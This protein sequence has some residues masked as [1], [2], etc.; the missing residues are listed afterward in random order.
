MREIR[1]LNNVS[2]TT[3]K[4]RRPQSKMR[5]KKRKQ[6]AILPLAV[7]LLI[8]GAVKFCAGQT[9]LVAQDATKRSE[10]QERLN[11]FDEFSNSMSNAFKKPQSRY[12]N[13]LLM[14]SVI[15]LGAVVV[16]FLVS[17][18]LYQKSRN[19]KEGYYSTE[20]LFKDLCRLHNFDRTDQ[21][22]LRK[23]AKKFQ[24]PNPL[25]L[26]VEP[27]FLEQALAERIVPYTQNQIRK[28]FLELFSTEQFSFTQDEK[29]PSWFAWT[30]IKDNPDSEQLMKKPLTSSESQVQPEQVKVQRWDPA[31]WED[32]DRAVKVFSTAMHPS[33]K[34]KQ[35]SEE[36][37][38]V[39]T[40]SVPSIKSE[41]EEM[42]TEMY[43]APQ[44]ESQP[45]RQAKYRD[46]EPRTDTYINPKGSSSQSPS[47]PDMSAPQQGID[48]SKRFYSPEPTSGTTYKP[49]YP[50]TSNSVRQPTQEIDEFPPQS[51]VSIPQPSLGSQI[52]SSLITSVS[53]IN[54][55][56]NAKSIRNNLTRFTPTSPSSLREKKPTNLADDIHDSSKFVPLD[57]IEV[58]PSV[59]NIA[60]LTHPSLQHNVVVK[61][62]EVDSKILDGSRM[63]IAEFIRRQMEGDENQ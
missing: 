17:V 38:Q 25:D 26:F 27:R 11:S 41:I 15:F 59:N 28:I 33:E 32:V 53:D 20:S 23:L 50:D 44:P 54:A 35:P 52:L 4:N 30:V 9:Y 13:A 58:L 55:E 1:S 22:V 16:I 24:L 10:K 46:F 7:I 2:L 14:G 19:T 48:T 49:Q 8:C 40:Y 37:K 47:E 39:T 34:V 56:V 21:T 51:G 62:I 6:F 3:A 18:N 36:P 57:E 31:L 63:T 5:S 42:E 60:T 61:P 12:N 45:E 43:N 29:P